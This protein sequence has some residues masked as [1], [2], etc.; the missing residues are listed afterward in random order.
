MLGVS[1]SRFPSATPLFPSSQLSLYLSHTKCTR[2]H[3]LTHHLPT[4][5]ALD[6]SSTSYLDVSMSPSISV[7]LF[8]PPFHSYHRALGALHL[9]L[10]DAAGIYAPRFR[11]CISYA[12]VRLPILCT[13]SDRESWAACS[14]E[15][16][17]ETSP[18]QVPSP[19]ACLV[20]A[21]PPTLCSTIPARFG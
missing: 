2:A 8:Y 10:S 21:I 7:P 13:C 9:S 5:P 19:S 14:L 18:A 6:S 15:F 11:Y 17:A 16:R 1:E 20:S 4:R 3:T 12:R